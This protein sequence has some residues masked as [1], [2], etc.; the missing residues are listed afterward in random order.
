MHISTISDQ[1]DRTGTAPALCYDG[2]GPNE[3]LSNSNSYTSDNSDSES[4][5]YNNYKSNY[6]S[7][8]EETSHASTSTTRTS[9][10]QPYA[11]YSLRKENFNND[12]TF[13]NL[14]DIIQKIFSL[15]PRDMLNDK[16]SLDYLPIY[17]FL[18]PNEKGFSLYNAYDRNEVEDKL[19][20]KIDQ[21][22][23][24]VLKFSVADDISEVFGLSEI[25]KCI[26]SQKP[27]RAVIDIDA[28]KEDMKTTSV[29]GQEVFI[30][31]CCSFIRALYRILDC[32]WEDILKGLVI[33]TSSDPNNR[34]NDLNHTRVQPPT[35]LRLEVRPRL[36]S[37]EKNNNPLRI[38]VGQD[39]LQNKVPLEC[40]L[41]KRIHDKDQQW[42]GRI[43]ATSGTF[44][45]KCFWQNNDEPEEPLIATEMYEERYV[46]P[47][48]NEGDIYVGSPWEMGKTYILENLSI[49]NNVNLL[50]LFTRHS[51]SNAI[52][53]RLNLK[54]YCDID[55]KLYKLVQD[56]RRII[57]MDN[58]L[59]VLNIEWIKTLRKDK[60]FSI[61]H[62]TFQPRKN[63]K[64]A[65]LICHLRKDVQGIVRALK[66]DF[67]ELRIKEYYGVSCTNP[68]F[69]R[70]FCLFN[71]YIEINARMN[72][73]LFRIR[74]IK[75]YVYH[76]KQRLSN[77]PITE[78]ELFQWLL[79]ARHECLPQELQNRGIFPDIDSIIRN[80]YVLTI[81]LWVAYMLKKFRSRC[82]FSWRIVDFLQNA[83]MVISIV[84]PIPK[85]D[86]NITLLSQVV[87][88]NSVTVKA[89]KI[90]EI[91]NANIL[92]HESAKFLENKPRKTLEEMH[93]L[94]W[95]HIVDCYQIPP[96]LLTE[97]FILEYGNYNHM[98]WFR[99]YRQ[100]LDART[101]NKTAVEAIAHKD[102]RK[103]KLTTATHAK[104]YQICLELLRNC[105]PTRDIDD[106]LRYKANDVKMHIDSPESISA[107]KSGLKT[108]IDKNS[109]HYHLVGFFDN[110][111]VPVLPPY[112]TGK[113]IYW[114]DEKDTWYGYS[115][116]SPD[117]ILM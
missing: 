10:V 110:K 39:V 113:E 108:A 36:L 38:I 26:N 21:E 56:A 42:F 69:E 66:T 61:I 84:E 55:K 67:P 65:S 6:E 104:R 105:T 59:T 62:N 89:E 35:S 18:F 79:N 5:D 1:T 60:Q 97:D 80:K 50:V 2:V 29:K 91:T 111:D 28:S 46:R 45:V 72:Q 25:H 115:E 44:I 92:D 32:G 83:G 15:P 101:N 86:E 98:K 48:P 31:I 82:L 114:V 107:K 41:C 95:H 30:R 77:A 116:L 58:D 78:K 90:S 37:T 12:F 49:P 63:Q 73:M 88:V 43:Y 4:D 9:L 47:L 13:K 20:I 87:K 106:R 99:A 51:Y 53:T 112:Q 14:L 40:P 103:D 33:A 7:D 96:E 3:Y 70:A 27:L 8:S 23:D 68:N 64:S 85:S 54:L 19:V 102:Y 74:C 16:G 93:S 76:I 100:P 34:W 57:V 11:I 22:D 71:S 75:D 109:R 24:Q 94:D 52:I 17:L 117:D 81:R